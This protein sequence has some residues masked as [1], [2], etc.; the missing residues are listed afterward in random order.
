[1][2]D[3]SIPDGAAEHGYAAFEGILDALAREDAAFEVDEFA[4][5]LLADPFVAE[6]DAGAFE[7][8]GGDA[9]AFGG[10][11]IAVIGP[12]TARPLGR[13]GLVPDLVAKEHVAESLARELLSAGKARSALLVRAQEARDVLPMSLRE[14]GL[15][16]TVVSAYA[17][18]KLGVQ[19]SS[20][21]HDLLQSGSIDAALLTSSSMADAL[22]TALGSSAQE[23]LSRTCVASIGPIT[24]STLQK[25]GVRVD[26]TAKVYTVEGLLDSLEQYFDALQLRRPSEV[27]C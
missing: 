10:A 26:V 1:M 20:R 9:R 15:H 7:G 17:T 27:K 21:L 12:G 14:A 25:A 5:I 18:R 3:S 13:W 2:I 4:E 19:Q 23:V 24:T 22:V 6:V 16:V 8:L 11:R